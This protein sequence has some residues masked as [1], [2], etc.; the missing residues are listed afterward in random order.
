MRGIIAVLIFSVGQSLSAQ[1]L[2]LPPR[3]TTAPKG[4]E[5]AAV[6]PGLPLA[7]REQKVLEAVRSGDVPLFIRKSSRR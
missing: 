4:A 5:S 3:P 7:G 2:E 6:V 1:S